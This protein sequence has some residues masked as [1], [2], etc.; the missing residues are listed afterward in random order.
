MPM[1]PSETAPNAIT[2]VRIGPHA[3][4]PGRRVLVVAEVGV[5]H[6]GS[7]ERA[8][9]LVDAAIQAGADAVKFQMFRADELVTAAAPTAAY[10]Q[11]ACGATSQREMLTKLELAFESFAHLRDYCDRKDVLYFATPFSVADVGRLV[12]LSVPAL[13]IASTDLTN[14]VLLQ[15]AVDT[16]LPMIVSTGASSGEEIRSNIS[17]LLASG[18]TGRLVLLHC[19]SCYPTPLHA[20]NL[21]AVAALGRASGVPCGFSD[22]T[23]ST[24]TGAWAVCAG[25]CLLEKHLTLDRGASGPDHA[26]SL[27]PESFRIYV[28]NVRLAETALGTGELGMSELERPV[29]EVAGRSV[30]SRCDITRG[31]VLNAGCLDVKRPG[32][33]IEPG[34]LD[35]LLG[36]RAVLDIPADTVL[37]WEMIE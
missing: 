22:H 4:G 5:N 20:A 34:R 11:E 17:R 37:S 36:R 30:V 28:E 18:A 29:R 12:K 16:G 8:L 13:K 15:A 25:A 24:Q 21:R 14:P 35:E 32:G 26:M 1:P 10:Q 7:M 6:D 9:S 19:V 27:D 31:T 3:V 23:T 33:G 2:P